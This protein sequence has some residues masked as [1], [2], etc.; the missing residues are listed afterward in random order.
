MSYIPPTENLNQEQ[1][2]A[3]PDKA[4][5]LVR[6]VMSRAVDRFGGRSDLMFNTACFQ[7]EWRNYLG[8]GSWLHGH[9]VRDMLHRGWYAEMLPGEAHWRMLPVE[10]RGNGPSI[11]HR[12]RPNAPKRAWEQG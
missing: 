12:P 8:V 7:R 2:M 3:Q 6:W 11:F 1:F 5:W 9:E 10:A 4:A